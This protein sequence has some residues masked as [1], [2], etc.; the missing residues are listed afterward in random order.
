MHIMWMMV[1]IAVF[2]M[3]VL[4][5]CYLSSRMLHFSALRRWAA[6]SRVKKWAVRL[7]P[8]VLLI[9][10]AVFDTVNTV[11]VFLHITVF[12]LVADLIAAIIKKA[13]KRTK[14]AE[15]YNTERTEQPRPYYAAWIAI[16]LCA[17]YL[18]IGWFCA[19]RVW[20]TDYT[21]KTEK[22]LGQ[23]KFRVA[24]IADS[25]IGSTFD[26]DGFAEYLAKMQETEPDILV[27]VGDFVDDS[28]TPEEMKRACA[29]F[30]D[31]RTK[32]GIYYVY[33][34]HDKG[35]YNSR[36]FTKD[37]LERELR[38]CGVTI[39]EDETVQL[40]EG[41]TLI[42]RKDRSDS[43]RRELKDL[44]AGINPSQYVIVLNH[45]PNDYAAEAEAGPDLVLSGHTHGGQMIPIGLIGRLS[46]ADDRSYGTETRGKTTFLVT[47]GISDWAIDFKTGTKSEYVIID[48]EGK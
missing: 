21:F 27:I 45:Q 11:M 10:A 34:N 9:L 28:T 40:T 13:R 44:M 29:A 4:S 5:L 2:V 48:I 39:L 18:T 31:F 20:R 36:G 12:W 25:H 30:R 6:D 37:D 32:Y 43:S 24:M 35:Y 14:E 41:I 38:E 26:G 46:G 47:S 17:V 8:L 7:I 22:A 23:E 1:L 42:G 19:H 33:G 15:P 16:G 3:S